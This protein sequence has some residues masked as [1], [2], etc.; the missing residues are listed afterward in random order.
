MHTLAIFPQLLTFE[1]IAPLLLR[2]AVGILLLM[3]GWKRWKMGPY[4]WTAVFYLV[5]SVLLIIGLYTQIATIV[6]FLVSGF[7]DY[8]QKKSGTL[9]KEK[10]TIGFLIAIILLSLLFTGPGFVAFDWPL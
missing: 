5:S 4:P 7:D 2:L 1:M 10:M 3:A 9:S 8:L 6:G